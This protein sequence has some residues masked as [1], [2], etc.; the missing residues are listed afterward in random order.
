MSF[1]ACIASDFSVI[2]TVVRSI[3]SILVATIDSSGVRENSPII[4]AVD[5]ET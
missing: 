3:G 5:N 1:V 2:S 4:S